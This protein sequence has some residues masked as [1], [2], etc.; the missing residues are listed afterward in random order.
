MRK[1]I[2]VI[3]TDA[4]K[5]SQSVTRGKVTGFLI[6]FF[7]DFPYTPGMQGFLD[8]LFNRYGNKIT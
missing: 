4:I 3:R 8:R 7:P 6:P 1:G 2:S 5:R